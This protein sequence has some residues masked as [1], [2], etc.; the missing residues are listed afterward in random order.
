MKVA[1]VG[2]GGIGSVAV[3]ALLENGVDVLC[4]E[5][6]RDAAEKLTQNGVR[7]SGKKGEHHKKIKAVVGFNGER[8]DLIVTAVKNNVLRDVFIEAGR[9]LTKN[10]F[11]ITLENGIQVLDLHE[12]FPEIPVVPGVVGYNS[13]MIEHGRYE[14]TSEGG[15]TIGQLNSERDMDLDAVRRIFSP[16]I[17]I[18]IT[19]NIVGVLWAKLL[20]V[21]GVTGLGGISGLRVGDLLRLKVARKLFYDIVTEGVEIAGRL[22]IRI[23]KFQ[24]GI[25]PAGFRNG[26]GFPSFVKYMILRIIGKRYRNLKSNIHHSIERG[27]KTEVDYLN[28]AVV[29]KGKMAGVSTPVNK[30]VVTV[31][32]EIESGIRQMTAENLYLIREIAGKD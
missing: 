8:F 4:I 7:L 9:H 22:G 20:I 21:C 2:C 18:D 24:G 28:G 10:G 19:E 26:G 15:I 17:S 25:N 32:K 16:L 27:E 3:C 1:V 5:G 13:I 12:E 29:E 31:T 11:I 6:S 23:E 14:V 30:A